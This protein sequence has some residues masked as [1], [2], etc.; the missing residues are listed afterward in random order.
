RKIHNALELLL[1]HPTLALLE[2]DITPLA[3]SGLRGFDLLVE[4]QNVFISQPE[5]PLA[6]VLE[7]FREHKYHPALEKLAIQ[8]HEEPIDFDA[9][10]SGYKAALHALLRQAAEVESSLIAEKGFSSQNFNDMSEE[11]KQR[12][13][14][15]I[16]K[17]NADK[18]K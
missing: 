1:Q 10:K 12:Y 4:L 11:E 13:N 3:N 7:R 16:R 5:L 8:D 6:V 2:I 17:Q 9:A 14:E 15:L 18:I